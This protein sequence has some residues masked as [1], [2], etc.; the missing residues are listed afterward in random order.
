[1]DNIREKKIEQIKQ[2]RQDAKLRGVQINETEER[3][4]KFA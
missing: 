3:D 1:M 2:K 4:K